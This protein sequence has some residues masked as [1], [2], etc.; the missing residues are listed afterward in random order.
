MYRYANNEKVDLCNLNIMETCNIFIGCTPFFVTCLDSHAP[1]SCT[2]CDVYPK[3][4]TLKYQDI[5]INQ[6]LLHHA[7]YRIPTLGRCRGPDWS[8]MQLAL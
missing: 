6:T 2:S 7:K 8:N 5:F 1:Y 4:P 3:Y